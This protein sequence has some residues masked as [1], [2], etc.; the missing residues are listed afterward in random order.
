MLK[1]WCWIVVVVAFAMGFAFAGCGKKANPEAAKQLCAQAA[2]ASGVVAKAAHQQV[3]D[4]QI[5][6]L[7]DDAAKSCQEQFDKA[8]EDE[9]PVRLKQAEDML[10]K[11]KDKKGEEFLTCAGMK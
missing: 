11:C 1:Q 9:K 4:A 5:K 8:P 6:K 10:A 3:P 7:V 2:E